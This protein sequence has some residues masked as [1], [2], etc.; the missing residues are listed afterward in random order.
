MGSKTPHRNPVRR[1]GDRNVLCPVYNSCLDLAADKKWRTF[2]CDKCV[3]QSQ[4]LIPAPHELDIQPYL[5]LIATVLGEN[6][7]A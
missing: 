1:M 2:C 5:A 6:R 4:Y 3:Y 7:A